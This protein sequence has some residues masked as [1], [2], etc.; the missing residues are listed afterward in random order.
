MVAAQADQPLRE[1]EQLALLVGEVP[2]VPGDLG[3]L[4]PGVVVAALRA[5]ELV[6]AEQHRRAVRQEQRRQEV[7]DLAQPQRDDLGVVRR[8]LDAA[9]PRAVVVGAVAV[10]LAVGL[11]VLGVVRDH[12]AQREAVVGGDEVDRGERVAPAV[13]VEVGGP[14]QARGERVRPGL[15]A[16]EVAH[17]V[18]VDAVPLAPQHGEVADLVA[19][20]ADVPRLGDQLHL[21]EH[22]V[23]VDRVEERRQ[24]VDVVEL[25]REGAREVEAEAVDVALDHPVA[26]RVHDHPQR[27]RV[28][29][30]ERVAGAG[31]VHVEALVVG[32][33]AV[34]GLVVDPLEGQDRPEVVALR[35][36]VVD[37]VEDHLDALAVQRLDHALELAH[38]LAVAAGRRVL[39]VRAEEADRRV[40]PVVGEALLVQEGLVGDLV[41]RQ[42][43]HRGHAEVLEVGDRRLGGEPRVG[44]AQ[45]LA[46]VGVLHREALDVRLVDH[47]V[48]PR[49]VR[50][51]V[52]LPVERAVDDEALRDRVGVVG[53]VALE[54]GVL[55]VA[56]HVRVDVAAVEADRPLDRLR[57]GVDEQLRR[58]EAV[59]AARV[60]RA[61]DAVAVALAGSDARQVD[62]PVVAG[63]SRVTSMRSSRSSASNRHSSTRWAFSENSEKF[64]PS[65]SYSGPSGNGRPGHTSRAIS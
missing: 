42:Q 45:V 50:R 17:R 34:V 29:D 6:A 35:G 41:D 57:V 40:A 1:V 8:P 52:A 44:A 30:V 65:P 32:D 58:V 11:V 38:L 21:A 5:A 39:G 19:A 56:G 47:G 26:Q 37:H 48:V 3:V 4:A 36:V 20:R 25:A 10:V 23:L 15:A 55:G 7:A 9:V 64:V 63:D 31:E 12:V 18:A 60:V 46:H 53:V 13:L 22:G 51:R 59:S 16:P 54:V 62:V 27:A 33:E 28:D 61:V 24:P 14:G 43:L 2:V 49:D